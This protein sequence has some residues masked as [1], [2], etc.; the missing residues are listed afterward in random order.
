MSCQSHVSDV[1]TVTGLQGL[2]EYD[3]AFPIEYA[4]EAVS[5]LFVHLL[6]FIL[7]R[8]TYNNVP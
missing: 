7:R 5:S 1:M 3:C 6:D 8:L 4:N 2:L